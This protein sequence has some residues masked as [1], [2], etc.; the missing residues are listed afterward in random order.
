MIIVA[1]KDSYVRPHKHSPERSESYHVIEGELE[2]TVYDDKGRVQQLFW[3]NE[4]VPF[5]RLRGGFYHEP[6]PVSE[7]VIY[8][9]VFTGPFDKDKDVIYADWAKA[10]TA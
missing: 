9:E 7:W 8:H 3:L 10:E 6:R 4:K 1:H 2:V 5:Y